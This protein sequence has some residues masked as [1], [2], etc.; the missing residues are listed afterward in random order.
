MESFILGS[1]NLIQ[2]ENYVVYRLPQNQ[3]CLIVKKNNAFQAFLFKKEDGGFKMV[4]GSATPSCDYQ[5][6]YLA[7][8]SL[9]PELVEII[10]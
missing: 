7:L 5:N 9:T 3:F 10:K 2:Y 4:A 1:K 8:T 6:I